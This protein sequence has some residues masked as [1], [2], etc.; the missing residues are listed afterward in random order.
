MA[1]VGKIPENSAHALELLNTVDRCIGNAFSG[2]ANIEWLLSPW[3]S[4]RAWLQIAEERGI[5]CHIIRRK[6]D[7]AWA[8]C[9]KTQTVIDTGLRSCEKQWVAA[10]ADIVF[11]VWNESVGEMDGA[12]FEMLEMA[13]S[14]HLPCVWISSDTGTSYLQTDQYYE[15]FDSLFLTNLIRHLYSTE[16]PAST[17]DEDRYKLLFQLG[18]ALQRRFLKK[19][20]PKHRKTLS[21][22]EASA[23]QLLDSG[24]ETTALR[25]QYENYDRDAIRCGDKYNSI[26]YFRAVLPA[27]ATVCLA[28]GFYAGDLVGMIRTIASWFV[29][30][31]PGAASVASWVAPAALEAALRCLAGIGFLLNAL[32]LY[33]SFK[34]SED[35]VLKYWHS[36]YVNSRMLAEA[37]CVLM[38]FQPYGV[39]VN[40]RKICGKNPYVLGV[41]RDELREIGMYSHVI[42]QDRTQEMLKSVDLMLKEQSIYHENS[43]MRYE[44]VST[45]VLHRAAVLKTVSLVTLVLRGLMQFAIGIG[46]IGQGD[47]TGAIAN[48]I[49]LLIP[50]YASYQVSKNDQ[51]RYSFHFENHK[52][53]KNAIDVFRL[54]L[55]ELRQSVETPS[56]EMLYSVAESLSEQMILE[57]TS[58][59][60]ETVSKT[61]FS[62]L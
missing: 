33:F 31:I 52:R 41:L 50:N 13:R 55:G 44:K 2:G 58:S 51:C 42:D 60:Y 54:R 49:A 21:P 19:H 30:L 6:S 20:S 25:Q 34:M 23:V 5:P 53:M 8:D 14:E 10:N 12:A 4:D 45:V 1:V 61:S 24:P 9:G 47:K 26:M 29:P 46:V 7:T 15:H 37:Y 28:I 43:V 22:E 3:F 40:I 17:P 16:P 39:S 35:R 11:A 59:W 56:V 32:L 57:D 62:R 38:H 18:A 36:R 48:T 27:Y